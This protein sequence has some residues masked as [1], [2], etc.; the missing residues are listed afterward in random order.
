MTKAKTFI[1]LAEFDPAQHCA[2]GFEFELTHPASGRGLGAFI[3]VIGAESADYIAFVRKE[4]G[5]RSKGKEK[6][7]EDAEKW[8]CGLLAECTIGWRDLGMNGAE[9]AFSKPEAR[10]LYLEHRWI[11]AQVDKAVHDLGNF[12]QD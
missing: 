1:D 7:V 6:T 12:M 11:R 8:A 9:V 5:P 3:T 10:R 4:I 2:K